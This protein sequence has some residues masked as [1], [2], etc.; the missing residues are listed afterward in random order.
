MDLFGLFLFYFY[1]FLSLIY[2]HGTQL[3]YT[4]AKIVSHYFH[5]VAKISLAHFEIL[6]QFSDTDKTV[7]MASP[8]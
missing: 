2:I 6:G 8:T 3:P 5:I 7:Q 1:F 4:E